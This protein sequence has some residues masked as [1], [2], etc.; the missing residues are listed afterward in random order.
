M[1]RLTRNDSLTT[2]T[3]IRILLAPIPTQ[4]YPTVRTCH[5]AASRC[6]CA[7]RRPHGA[8]GAS[9]GGGDAAA[10]PAA[11]PP[12]RAALWLRS[13]ASVFRSASAPP[14]MLDSPQPTLGPPGGQ[15]LTRRRGWQSVKKKK[16]GHRDVKNL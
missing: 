2:H 5:S 9:A 12:S 1:D 3:P 10:A 8:A 4:S 14:A 11:P 16:K 7:G 13:V 6:V 15:L